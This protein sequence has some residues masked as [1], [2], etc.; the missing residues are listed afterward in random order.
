MP[1]LEG[2]TDH[3]MLTT[4]ERADLVH[5]FYEHLRDLRV[6]QAQPG[7]HTCRI[8]V[9]LNEEELQAVVVALDKPG[10]VP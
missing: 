4:S 9:A 2:R 5:K 1:V 6:G 3:P 8:G 7:C 10:L